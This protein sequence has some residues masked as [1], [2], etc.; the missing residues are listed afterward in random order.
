MEG[1]LKKFSCQ[2]VKPA[3]P[4]RHPLYVSCERFVRASFSFFPL[5]IF[6][7][8]GNLLRRPATPWF[9]PKRPPYKSSLQ[10]RL[11]RRID[12]KIS[13]II[14]LFSQEIPTATRKGVKTP[15]NLAR[16]GFPQDG[17]TVLAGPV[18][19]SDNA[20]SFVSSWS[21]QLDGLTTVRISRCTGMPFELRASAVQPAE[22][23]FWRYYP[24]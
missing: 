6:S 15:R 2:R 11:R 16:T 4:P 10:N 20:S 1:F 12:Q 21:L 9:A 13:G 22:P 14:F 24:Q 18:V 5:T 3:H 19:C 8:Q 7:G 17:W 23:F